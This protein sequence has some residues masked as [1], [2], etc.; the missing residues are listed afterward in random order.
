MGSNVLADRH[1]VGRNSSC[2]MN[3]TDDQFGNIEGYLS[4]FFLVMCP[5]IATVS[6][7]LAR[8]SGFLEGAYAGLFGGCLSVALSI[9]L[10]IAGIRFAGGL[11]RWI[12]GGVLVIWLM[13]ILLHAGVQA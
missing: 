8:H 4:L 9:G 2:G 1:L 5:Q 12:A 7:L 13:L 3:A 6:E 10:A 11:P